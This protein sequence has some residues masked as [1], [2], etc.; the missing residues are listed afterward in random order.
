[1]SNHDF[2]RVAS[3][4][5]AGNARAAALL[6]LCLGGAA[7]VY[8]GEEIGMLDGPEGTRYDRWGRDAC[9]YPM[10]WTAEP[11]GGFTTG[12]PWLEPVDPERRSVESQR[13]DPGS[14][15]NL[16][17][18]LISARR[19]IEGAPEDIPG[20]PP[21]VVGFRRGS[22]AVLVNVEGED[23]APLPLGGEVVIESSP[24][25]LGGAVEEPLTLARS[26]AVLLR[27]S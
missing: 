5:G 14:I 12:E 4:W 20:L 22:H 24:G 2:S 11:S 9:R 16:F 15:L 1:M 25:I 13:G 10:Q 19:E 27:L 23:P 3:R 18:R 8:Q 26:G 6:L 7:F 21:G 17:R